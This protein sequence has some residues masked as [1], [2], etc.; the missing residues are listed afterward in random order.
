MDLGSIRHE[1][2]VVRQTLR[3]RVDQRDPAQDNPT[4]AT[5]ISR[6][7]IYRDG[8]L[9]DTVASSSTW[10]VSACLWAWMRRGPIAPMR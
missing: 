8:A 5:G 4:N 7:L 6:Y 3:Q 2:R 10:E 1:R 9:Y